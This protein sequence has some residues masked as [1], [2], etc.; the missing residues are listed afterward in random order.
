V[1]AVALGEQLP[2]LAE[3]GAIGEAEPQVAVAVSA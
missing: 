3:L 1:Q 2:L